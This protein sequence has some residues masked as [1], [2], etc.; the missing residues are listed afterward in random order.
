MAARGSEGFVWK[1]MA[2]SV[3]MQLILAKRCCLIILSESVCLVFCAWSQPWVKKSVYCEFFCPWVCLSVLLSGENR[4]IKA[5]S[6]LW[7]L[8][9]NNDDVNN[10]SFLTGYPSSLCSSSNP[11]D[12][13]LIITLEYINRCESATFWSLDQIKRRHTAFVNT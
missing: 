7:I 8:S 1:E 4:S 12:M 9:Q 13:H 11:P 5:P 6:L 2:L 3:S 10:R